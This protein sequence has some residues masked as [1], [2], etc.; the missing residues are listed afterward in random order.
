MLRAAS[1]MPATTSS[2]TAF[3]LAPGALNTGMPRSDILAIGTLLVPDPARPIASSASGISMACKSA[4][5][6]RMAC[7]S[8]T[9][10]DTANRSQG[11]R[12]SPPAEMLL[13][14]RTRYFSVMSASAFRRRELGHVI[15][16]RL[17]AFD[18]H[19]VVERCA[20][21]TD[22]AVSLQLHQVVFCSA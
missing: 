1:N 15:H 9:S 4:E 22:R 8:T 2:L 16:Q 19:R 10:A 18:R 3:A 13:R 14:T 12:F 21:A 5:R 17:D 6:T 20:H 11:K 7:G